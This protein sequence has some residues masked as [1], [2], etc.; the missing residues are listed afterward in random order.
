AYIRTP[1]A[2]YAF[3]AD[4]SA[5]TQRHIRH[6]L[7][8]HPYLAR[9]MVE[10]GAALPHDRQVLLNKQ[11]RRHVIRLAKAQLRAGQPSA[12]RQTLAVSDVLRLGTLG[13][14]LKAATYLPGWA[15][16]VAHRRAKQLRNIVAGGSGCS[17]G[18][19]RRSGA[20]LGVASSLDQGEERA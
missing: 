12:A 9:R 13:W 20:P 4:G 16:P 7:A 15:T 14:C 2:N 6:H 5:L 3:G 19:N 17:A 11:A 1:I 10:L 8:D 18:A